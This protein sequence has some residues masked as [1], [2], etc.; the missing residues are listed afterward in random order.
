MPHYEVGYTRA[1]GVR[2]G[3]PRRF[4][5]FKIAASIAR[6]LRADGMTDIC[7]TEENEGGDIDAVWRFINGVL[8]KEGGAR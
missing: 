7:I 1:D 2:V 8:E 4:Y 5:K 3:M 6:Q